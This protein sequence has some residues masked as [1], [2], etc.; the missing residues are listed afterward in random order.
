MPTD[1][2]IPVEKIAE[3]ARHEIQIVS[4]ILDEKCMR[5]IAAV[6]EEDF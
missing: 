3:K 4:G 2:F 1:P 5:Q 6:R